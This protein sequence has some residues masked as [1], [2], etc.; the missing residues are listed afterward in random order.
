[1]S[2]FQHLFYFL[3][4][5]FKNILFTLFLDRGEG[6]KKERERNNNV[7]LPLMHNSRVAYSCCVLGTWPAVQACA[8]IVNRTGDPWVPRPA[9]NP[10]SHSSQGSFSTFWCAEVQWFFTSHPANEWYICFLFTIATVS[11][12]LPGVS[13]FYS[14][15]L[16]VLKMGHPIYPFCGLHWLFA[17]AN[18]N[19]FHDNVERYISGTSSNH[20]F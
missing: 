15:G 17:S 2:A 12:C 11:S 1:M 16:S 9:L 13:S 20:P 18:L 3:F 14:F 7:W 8:L 19:K 10:L 5:L 6:R 4:L